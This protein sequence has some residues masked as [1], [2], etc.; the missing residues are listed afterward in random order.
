MPLLMKRSKELSRRKMPE[1]MARIQKITEEIIQEMKSEIEK[2]EAQAK[3]TEK[4]M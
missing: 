2:E 3:Q 1:I 4:K